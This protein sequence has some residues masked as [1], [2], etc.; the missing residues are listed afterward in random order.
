MSKY[1]ENFPNLSTYDFDTIM[2]QLKQVCGADP[3]GLINAQ[4]LSRPT[5]AKDIALLLHITYQLFQSQVEL[6]KQFVE[7]YTFVKDFFENL[8]LQEEVNNWLNQA[9]LD[10]TLAGILGNFLHYHFTFKNYNEMLK[11]SNIFKDN[12]FA[13]ILGYHNENDGG[14][15]EYIIHVNDDNIAYE[16][17]QLS[18]KIN[19]VSNGA[20]SDGTMDISGIVNSLIDKYG[21]DE[22]T[23][24]T[25]E[26]PTIVFP[27]GEYLINSTITVNK[28]VKFDFSNCVLK[29]TASPFFYVGNLNKV[30]LYGVELKNFIADGSDSVSF[31]TIENCTE[32]KMTDGLIYNFTPTTGKYVIDLINTGNTVSSAFISSIRVIGEMMNGKVSNSAKQ[33]AIR[34][35]ASDTVFRDL[36][37]INFLQHYLMG[38]SSQLIGCHA[39]N[40][41]ENWEG[42]AMIA[43][44][45]NI[46]GSLLCSD[47]V[48]DTLQIFDN[49]NSDS[50]HS[51]VN[52][53]Y[54]M[55]LEAVSDLPI[56]RRDSANSKVPYLLITNLIVD[57]QNYTAQLDNFNN[58]RL[59]IYEN[60]KIIRGN[61]TPAYKLNVTQNTIEGVTVELFR[62][63]LY[64][65]EFGIIFNANV[66]T[67]SR[68]TYVIC[69]LSD[70]LY[71]GGDAQLNGILKTSNGVNELN[72]FYDSSSKQIKFTIY[73]DISSYHAISVMG[74][75]PYRFSFGELPQV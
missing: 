23:Y 35:Y 44:S 46:V 21:N 2:C 65:N 70:I 52:C 75:I 43:T 25:T 37:T 18:N 57:A 64:G 16:L 20:Y 11:S 36:V 5:T 60:I 61:I 33:R 49:L 32:F 66:T 10:G 7:L 4:F 53:K 13:Y 27:K 55:P 41:A 72:V 15:G 34:S 17:I 71:C 50:T 30:S 9:L 12:T 8:N 73:E 39:W 68:G 42:S 69:T 67:L 6:Q 14:S 22:D 24:P 47:C 38:G 74:V 59:P 63:G 29:G 28:N 48:C 1:T 45:S 51:L 31:I 58:A 26:I 19:V 54:Y 62:A 40:S 56:F 3:S